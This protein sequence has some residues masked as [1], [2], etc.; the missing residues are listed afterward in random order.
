VSRQESGEGENRD[1][2]EF[3]KE[4]ALAGKA[5]GLFSEASFGAGTESQKQ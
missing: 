5:G 3:P 2:A 4:E 1:T